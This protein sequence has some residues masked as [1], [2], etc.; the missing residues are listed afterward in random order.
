MSQK[1]TTGAAQ[2]QNDQVRGVEESTDSRSSFG[3]RERTT[4]RRRAWP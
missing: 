4:S 3:D 1:T 2:V